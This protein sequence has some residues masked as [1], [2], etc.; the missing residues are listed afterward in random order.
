MI[1]IICFAQLAAGMEVNK[2]DFVA[3]WSARYHDNPAFLEATFSK[4]DINGD[5]VFDA[6]EIDGIVQAAQAF[7]KS[8]TFFHIGSS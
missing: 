7:D 6:Q 3:A 5:D 4:Y 2:Q 1:Y 8:K